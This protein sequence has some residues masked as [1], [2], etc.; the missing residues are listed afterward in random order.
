MSRG[1]LFIISAPSGTGKTSLIA[2]LLA[3]DPQLTESISHTTR[4][5]RPKEKTGRDYHFVDE[6]TFRQMMADGAFLEH[7]RVFGNHYGTSRAAV[8]RAL[9]EGRDVIL[10]IDWQGAAAVRAGMPRAVSIFIVPPSQDALRERLQQRAQDDPAVIEARLAE[11]RCEIR[12]H[13]EF[14]YL[15]INDDF[16]TALAELRAIVLAER[17]RLPYRA[18]Q[19]R[20][21]LEALTAG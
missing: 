10:N 2:E 18:E 1:I 6:A 9:G 15:V 7:A 17:C 11:A 20:A 13:D 21:L 12:H 16:E 14:D 19:N 3:A 8:V 5:R 4:P